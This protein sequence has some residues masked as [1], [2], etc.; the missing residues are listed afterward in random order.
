M[1]NSHVLSVSPNLFRFILLVCLVP[2]IS[3]LSYANQQ[4]TDNLDQ[5]TVYR[6]DLFTESLKPILKKN[7]KTGA[8]YFRY[9]SISGTSCLEPL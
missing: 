2:L 3:T 7:L 9:S 5:N 6:L 8:V 1:T 4:N